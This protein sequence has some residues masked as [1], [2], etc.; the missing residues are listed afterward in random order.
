LEIDL[1]RGVERE[2]KRPASHLT[3]WVLTSGGASLRSHPHE[4]DDGDDQ[5]IHGQG[6]KRKC[7]FNYASACSER[8]NKIY[9]NPA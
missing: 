5:K 8:I 6:S 4:L 1:E 3:Y 7:G 9:E 2:L